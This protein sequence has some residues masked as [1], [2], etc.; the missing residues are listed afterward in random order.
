MPARKIKRKK[1]LVEGAEDKRVIPELIEA[2]GVSWGETAR[3]AI[4]YIKEFDGIEN[5]LS[6]N[7]ISTELKDRGLEIIGIIADADESVTD[8][9]KQIRNQCSSIFPG[10][11]EQI[12]EQGLIHHNDKGL[13]LGVWIMPDNRTSGMLETFLTY[14]VPDHQVDSV[15]KH[16]KASLETAMKIGTPC[17]KHH[18]DKARV[19]TWL[20]WQNP[21][22]RQLHNAVMER[23]FESSHPK[24]QPFVQWFKDL[25]DV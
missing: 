23:I 21:P 20:A 8:R 13:K 12:P 1:L 4:V 3:Q 6:P 11:P 16:A 5:L 19:H 14:L 18:E 17:K 10:L 22:G 7:V 15:W 25:Y 9:W 2:N 24:A